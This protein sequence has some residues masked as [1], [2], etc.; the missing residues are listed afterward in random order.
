MAK[1]ITEA[2]ESEIVK[3]YTEGIGSTRIGM[4]FA[5]HPVTVRGILKRYDIPQRKPGDRRKYHVDSDFFERIDTEDKAYWLGFLVADGCIY[6]NRVI[7][8][9]SSTDR[10]H[11][12]KFKRD[13]KAEYPIYE[14]QI[15]SKRTGRISRRSSIHITSKKLVSDLAQWGVIPR[16]TFKTV[17]PTLDEHWARHFIRGVFDGDGTITQTKHGHCDSYYGQFAIY[18]NREFLLKLQEFFLNLGLKRTQID[19]LRGR[20]S[21]R[22]KYKGT[23]NL[24]RIY[25]YLYSRAHIYLDRKKRKFEECIGRRGP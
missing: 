17:F 12:R 6:G 23:H 4:K 8:C 22:L 24:R 5:I 25:R 14:S 1:K 16:K 21:H 9:L 19:R 13:I 3:L 10:G 18:G 20:N 11:I 15:T 2:Q 7:L